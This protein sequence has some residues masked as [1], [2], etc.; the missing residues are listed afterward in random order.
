MKYC[1]FYCVY[2][3]LESFEKQLSVEVAVFLL[4]ELSTNRDC[5]IIITLLIYR[6][7]IWKK[8]D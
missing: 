1:Y 3:K 4:F 2:T 8:Y 7:E 5:F 6:Y